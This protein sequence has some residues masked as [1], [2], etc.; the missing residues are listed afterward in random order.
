MKATAQ[1]YPI[2]FLSPVHQAI[3]FPDNGRSLLMRCPL[4]PGLARIRLNSRKEMPQCHSTLQ[5][6][7]RGHLALLTWE[8]MVP[9]ASLFSV[10]KGISSYR[11]AFANSST[12]HRVRLC[13]R[14]PQQWRLQ[15]CTGN[16]PALPCSWPGL[17]MA[18]QVAC[19]QIQ[20]S[21][22]GLTNVASF[23]P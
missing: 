8:F 4:L 21:A 6:G 5:C 10:R 14:S 16:N 12:K 17:S 1:F 13:A 15:S 9:S 7:N 22:V 18:N 23:F 2:S 20:S 3:A 19:L 11:G